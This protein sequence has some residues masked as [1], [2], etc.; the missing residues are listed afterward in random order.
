MLCIEY[1]LRKSMVSVVFSLKL[2]LETAQKSFHRAVLFIVLTEYCELFQIVF[3]C[4]Y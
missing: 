3:D 4:W 2:L 1:L